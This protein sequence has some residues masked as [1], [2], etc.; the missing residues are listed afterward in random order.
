MIRFYVI[1]SW[2]KRK[3]NISSFSIKFKHMTTLT[4]IFIERW[5]CPRRLMTNDYKLILA[6]EMM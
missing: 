6:N 4:F 5:N 3:S 1:S 2:V